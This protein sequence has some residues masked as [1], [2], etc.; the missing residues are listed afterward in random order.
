MCGIF[1]YFGNPLDLKLLYESF[2][3]TSKRG[4]DNNILKQITNNLVFG[5]HRL[6]IM[7]TSFKGDQPLYHPTK[8]YSLICNG[9]IY[10]FQELK[11]EYNINTYSDSD[12]EII[13]YLYERF[14]IKK[15]LQLLDTESFAICLHDGEK[16]QFIVA[17]DRFGVRPLFKSELINDENNTKHIIFA[18]ECKS[19][20][21]LVLNIDTINAQDKNDVKSS[22]IIEQFPTSTYHIY[23]EQT[24]ELLEQNTYYDKPYKTQTIK[25][26]QNRDDRYMEMYTDETLVLSKIKELFTKA[27]HKRLMAEREIGCLLSGGLDSSLV[28]AIVAREFKKQGLKPLNTFAIGIEGSTDLHYAKLVADHIGSNH[29]SIELKEQDFLDAIPE[30]IKMIESYDTTTV[31]ASVGNYLVGKYIK[32][33]TDITVVFNGDGS[34]EQSGYLYLSNAPDEIAFQKECERLMDEIHYF[35]VLRSDRALSSKWSLETRAPFL[36][37]DFVDYYMSVDPRLKMY[38]PDKNINNK[39]EKENIEKYLLRKTFD[40]EDLLPDEVLWRRKEAFSDGCSAKTRS[41][42]TIIQE[43]IDGKI[44]D[45]EFEENKDKYTHNKPELK[46]SYYYRKIFDETFPNRANIIPHFWLPRWCGNIKD[47]SARELDNYKK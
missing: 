9:E 39:S 26:I 41:W 47:P 28:S 15:T 5:F 3:K 30:V 24:Y 4:P 35:D 20:H 40:K 19:I 27:V 21:D 37:T 46:E 7:D 18:S 25:T 22:T 17:R 33:Y 12:C 45:K 29:H 36:D 13:L 6:A 11:T 42:H 31:R 38:S 1:A 23:D 14:G 8:P 2:M 32:K 10:N 44:T 34:D 16:K 43:Y